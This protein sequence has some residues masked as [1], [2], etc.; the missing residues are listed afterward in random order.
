[1]LQAALGAEFS[2]HTKGF[3]STNRFFE[4]VC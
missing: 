1:M 3:V 2:M 4:K